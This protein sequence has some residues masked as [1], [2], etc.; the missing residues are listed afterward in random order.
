MEILQLKYFLALARS[1]HVTKTAQQLHIAQPAL[2]QTIHR[3]ENEL[4]VRLFQSSGRNIILTEEGRYLQE[5]I[6]PVVRVLNELPMQLQELQSNRKKVIRINVLAA[7]TIITDA[8]IDFQKQHSGFNFQLVQNNR[9]EDADITVFTRE[10]FKQP[11]STKE[12]YAVFTEQ[13]YLAVPKESQYS[14]QESIELPEIA[15]KE[16]IALA[17]SKGL[18]IICDRFCMHA[19][20]QP[21]VIFESDS[22]EVVKNLIGASIGVGFWPQY[23]WG[24]PDRSRMSL[25]PIAWPQCQR[26]IV[27]QLHDKEEKA[28]DAQEFFDF[29]SHYLQELGRDTDEK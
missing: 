19:G 25:I 1:Q 17:G 12:A 2:T 7:S 11:K 10:C 4:G 20:F 8:I 24:K 26:D 29:L 23:S 9:A 14:R 22:P 6:E 28:E 5:K 18:R 16:F 13:I 21:N 3:L 15:E 27:V